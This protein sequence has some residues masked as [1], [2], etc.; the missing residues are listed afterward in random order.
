[1]SDRYDRSGQLGTDPGAA[2]RAAAA[3]PGMR[4]LIAVPRSL[5][6]ASCGLWAPRPLRRLGGHELR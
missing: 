1:M 6:E 3:A 4:T 2:P 5:E